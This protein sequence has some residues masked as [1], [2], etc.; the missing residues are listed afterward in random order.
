[1]YHVVEVALRTTCL[2][3]LAFEFQEYTPVLVV[4]S[5]L[6]RLLIWYL[7]KD[8]A[9]VGLAL[10]AIFLDSVFDKASSFRAAA[11]LTMV[12]AALILY[13]SVQPI[14]LSIR[15][16][17]AKY[18]LPVS[19][20]WGC[21]A[22]MAAIKCFLHM[23]IVER[24]GKFSESESREESKASSSR[25]PRWMESFIS[26]CCAA[27]CTSMMVLQLGEADI[28][29][30]MLDDDGTKTSAVTP[31]EALTVTQ[32]RIHQAPPPI[33]RKDLDSAFFSSLA[34]QARLPVREALNKANFS[35]E[36]QTDYWF[37][38]A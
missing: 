30:D 27:V 17:G 24:Y 25:V 1:M 29:E 16:T 11:V 10:G 35:S 8:T 37:N 26:C 18:N 5:L 14:A 22:G 32:Q 3:F 23:L 6:L 28:D 21:F 36:Q 38:S 33:L 31:V 20:V 12:E 7:N 34:S 19:L 15:A 13:L 4:C 2:A 9:P